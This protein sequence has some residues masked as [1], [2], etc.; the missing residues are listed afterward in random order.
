[1]TM[2]MYP[3][4][5]KEN[6][7]CKDNPGES[8][9]KDKFAAVRNRDS[10][11]CL[12]LRGVS[13]SSADQTAVTLDSASHGLK[14]TQREA[15]LL[16]VDAVNGRSFRF[17]LY[18]NLPKADIY[19]CA[20][21]KSLEED[22]LIMVQNGKFLCDPASLNHICYMTPMELHNERVNNER[23]NQGK[24]GKRVAELPSVGGK[25]FKDLKQVELFS[26]SIDFNWCA[27]H[28]GDFTH[29]HFMKRQASLSDVTKAAEILT[30]PRVGGEAQKSE[31]EPGESRRTPMTADEVFLHITKM[32]V[33]YLPSHARRK[34]YVDITR[35]LFSIIYDEYFDEHSSQQVNHNG[36]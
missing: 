22:V 15:A 14:G 31:K 27:C 23:L 7:G 13:L 4:M 29:E 25:S 11:L 32:A 35:Y 19:A 2:Q 8:H 33:G 18:R 26:S 20:K 10:S 9:T 30:T 16:Y 1:M 36:I 34:A 17:V 6:M 5:E 12:R 21:C 3:E 28:D 24:V